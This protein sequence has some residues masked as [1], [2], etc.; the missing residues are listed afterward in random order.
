M[1][2]EGL[3]DPAT[4]TITYIVS[5]EKSKRAIV[6]DPVLDYEPQGSIISHESVDR[7]QSY[8]TQNELSL[9][10]ILETHAHA[11]H[12]SGSQELK[13]R[14]PGA[15]IGINCQIKLVQETFKPVFNLENLAVDGSQFDVLLNEEEP[16]KFGDLE[17]QTIFTPGHTPACSSF[18]IE[19]ALFS[20]DVLFM[21][22]FGTGRC[23]FPAGSAKD[24]YNSVQNKLYKLSDDT[25][26]FVGHDYQPGGRGLKFETTI[27]ESK[28]SNIR[29]KPETTEADFIKV[30]AERDSDL[31]APKLIFQSVQVNIDAGRLPKAEN[32]DQAYL[33]MP[34][35][36][37]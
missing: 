23:D 15:K 32:N 24:M 6:I 37:K 7:V 14:N 26:V 34:L 19:D 3:F 13:R 25:R 12:L 1:K 10:Y 27:G 18:L 11:D 20:G 35:T 2:I 29:I 4:Y 31:K 33:K 17:L 22:D 21:P 16:L 28:A 5:D 8:L 9:D 36:I 30:R